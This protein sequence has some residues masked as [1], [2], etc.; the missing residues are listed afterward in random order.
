MASV[1]DFKKRAGVMKMAL[2][3]EATRPLT[4][5]VKQVD[6]LLAAREDPN[7][8]V[9]AL[10]TLSLMSMAQSCNHTIIKELATKYRSDLCRGLPILI[11]QILLIKMAIKE[12]DERHRF[13]L[14]RCNIYLD[15]FINADFWM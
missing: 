11:D 2:I 5:S 12:L 7:I 15:G 1:S 9:Y 13:I 6:I 4:F 14:E 8:R 10:P 3:H